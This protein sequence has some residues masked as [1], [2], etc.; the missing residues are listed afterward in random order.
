MVLRGDSEEVLLRLFLASRIR[1]DC[2]VPLEDIKD[3]TNAPRR[4]RLAEIQVDQGKTSQQF[5]IGLE[6]TNMDICYPTHQK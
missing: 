6:E 5:G 3:R 4:F 2:C 1:V